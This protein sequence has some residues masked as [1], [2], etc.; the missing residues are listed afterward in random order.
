MP[1]SFLFVDQFGKSW[2]DDKDYDYDDVN[3]DNIDDWKLGA[4]TAVWT[5]KEWERNMTRCQKFAKYD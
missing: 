4:A 1:S 3:A 2:H 5:G